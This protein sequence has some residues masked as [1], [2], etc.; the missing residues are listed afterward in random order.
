LSI[1]AQAFKGAT[2]LGTFKLISQVFS[3]AATIIVA[4]TLSPEDYGLM[5]MA[6][7]LTGYA[8]L[9]NELGLG[10]AIIQNPDLKQKELSSVFWFALS[11]SLVLAV[12]SLFLAYPTARIFHE[13]RVVPI[14]MTVSVIFLLNGLQVIPLALMRRE[15]KFK[16]LG[17]NE[18]CGVLLSSASMLLMARL[19]FGV[20]TLLFGYIV[21]SGSRLVLA[22]VSE[23]WVPNLHFAVGEAKHFIKFGIVVAVGGSFNYVCEKS[24]RYFAGRVWPASQLGQYT[25]ALELA[26]LPIDKVVSLINQVSFSAFS[27]LQTEKERFNALYLRITKIT[28]IMVLPLFVGGFLIGDDLVRVFLNEKWYPMTTVFRYLCLVQIAT[29][30][31]AV[32]NFVHTA[33]GRPQ[34]RLYYFAACALIMPFSFALA[35]GCG[36]QAIILPWTTSY[37]LLCGFW[38]VFTLRK[39][40]IRVG[41]FANSLMAPILAV[42]AMSVAIFLVSSLHHLG[43]IAPAASVSMLLLKGI[44]GFLTYCA[45]VLALDRRFLKDAMKLARS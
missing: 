22:F 16:A 37:F 17:I 7:I 8:M 15:L 1:E 35:V 28:A 45:V 21:N 38:I 4:R 11:V 20:W 43:R 14:T 29:A 44:A 34:W 41:T 9:F 19:G 30:L 33:L 18:M 42:S 27:R 26:Q 23:K 5:A 13:P 2:W 40:G 10:A 24:D 39:I 36:F 25:F 3:W 31:N 32:N 12:V 6:T